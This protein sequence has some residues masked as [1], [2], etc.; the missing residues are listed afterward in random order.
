MS[1]RRSCDEVDVVQRQ[2]QTFP[3]KELGPPA[4]CNVSFLYQCLETHLVLQGLCLEELM[5]LFGLRED[6]VLIVVAEAQQG[7]Q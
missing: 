2:A 3:V 5:K 1:P 4:T 7:V 6:I